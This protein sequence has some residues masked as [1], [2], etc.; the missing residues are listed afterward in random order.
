MPKEI[1]KK[2]KEYE[3]YLISNY[4]IVVSLKFGKEKILKPFKSNHKNAYY[5]IAFSIKGKVKKE[6]LHRLLAKEFIDNPF[7]KKEV[8]HKNGNKLDNRLKN[9][10]WCT[11]QENTIH[12]RVSGLTPEVTY[13]KI[14]IEQV[15]EIRLKYKEGNFIQSEL[16]KQYGISVSNISAIVNKRTWKKKISHSLK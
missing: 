4:G 6:A 11:H 5:Q 15:E 7:N 1:W 2:I 16:A 9:I 10:E 12:A 3:G 14:S 8:N 13:K